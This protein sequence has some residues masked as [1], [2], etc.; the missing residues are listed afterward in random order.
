MPTPDMHGFSARFNAGEDVRFAL[1]HFN[2]PVTGGSFTPVNYLEEYNKTRITDL[3]AFGDLVL[4]TGITLKKHYQHLRKNNTTTTDADNLFSE[5]SNYFKPSA[6]LV[7]AELKYKE[8]I[9]NLNTLLPTLSHTE[10]KKRF[11]KINTD[12]EA[13]ITKEYDAQKKKIADL[14]DTPSRATDIDKWFDVKTA[15]QRDHLK[16][17]LLATLETKHKESFDTAKKAVPSHEERD[18]QFKNNL[19]QMAEIAKLYYYPRNRKYIWAALHTRKL[20]KPG[21]SL[22]SDTFDRDCLSAVD[23]QGNGLTVQDVYDEVKRQTLA[24]SKVNKYLNK[25]NPFAQDEG[26]EIGWDYGRES[27][28]KYGLGTKGFLLR[29]NENKDNFSV[30]LPGIQIKTKLSAIF[31]I[32]ALDS[33]GILTMSDDDLKE[34][35][36]AQLKLLRATKE[37]L[38]ISVKAID[39]KTALHLARLACEEAL[40]AGFE[41]D[42]IRVQIKVDRVTKVVSFDDIFKGHQG[43]KQ[44]ID[45][46]VKIEDQR[47]ND[48]YS[49]AALDPGQFRKTVADRKV[50][51][52]PKEPENNSPA[53]K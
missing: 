41:Q 27:D 33:F 31:I 47:R 19:K 52:P 3:N 45:S 48:I 38:T 44:Q 36:A 9:K 29:Y 23:P 46:K 15:D 8:D 42:K 35:L 18:K 13:E 28:R 30:N 32:K 12:F 10:A 16:K 2:P 51:P 6:A 17:G 50:T 4:P 49:M 53:P 25:L 26:L 37:D 34:S 14:C 20:I 39:E 24:V 5:I 40:L 7:A 1:R 21:A 43:K 11:N 22:Q